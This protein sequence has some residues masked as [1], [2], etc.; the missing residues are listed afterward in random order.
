M[1]LIS[2]LA[3]QKT[4]FVPSAEGPYDIPSKEECLQAFTVALSETLFDSEEMRSFVKRKAEETFDNDYDVFYPYIKDEVVDGGKTFRDMLLIYFSSESELSIIEQQLPLLTI[5]VPDITWLDD[6]AF[7]LDNWDTSSN[8]IAAT[9]SLGERCHLVYAEGEAVSEVKPG[10][11]PAC[12]FVVVK[13]NE[14]VRYVQTKGGEAEYSFIS[15]TFDAA[16]KRPETKYW[17]PFNPQVWYYYGTT[18]D[19]SNAISEETL[20]SISPRTLTAYN[21]YY[22]LGGCPNDYIFYDMTGEDSTGHLRQDVRSRI[23]RFKLTDTNIASIIDDPADDEELV[24]EIG[25]DD[26]TG[27]G[28][29]GSSYNDLVG[30]FLSEGSLELRLDVI[31]PTSTGGCSATHEYMNVRPKDLYAISQ[32]KKEYWKSTALKWYQDWLYS[33]EAEDIHAKWYYPSQ[34]PVLPVWNLNGGASQY[35]LLFTEED[36]GATYKSSYTATTK[37]SVTTTNTDDKTGIGTSTLIETTNTNTIDLQ[38][39]YTS[40]DL[41]Q[42]AINYE[43][44]YIDGELGDTYYLTT[45]GNSDSSI[46]FS[47][48]PM[49]Y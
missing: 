42:F 43:D 49:S 21:E 37:Y 35:C 26:A 12:P 6:D 36:S 24:T 46:I 31:T 3:C 33:Y 17:H 45:Y 9:Y 8:Q 40:D 20:E 15:D 19:T 38:I 41:G 23:Y 14:R 11:I 5:Y 30:L 32:I 13:E 16:K 1:M 27:A 7:C 34:G 10:V 4:T 22:D 25:S 39:T 2:I 28:D 48:L 18:G 47:I 29:L 44:H